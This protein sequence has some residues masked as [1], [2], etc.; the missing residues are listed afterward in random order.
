MVAFLLSQ[1]AFMRLSL[2][3]AALLFQGTLPLFCTPTVVVGSRHY[4]NHLMFT[5]GWK[6]LT[7]GPGLST[8]SRFIHTSLRSRSG[9]SP[10]EKLFTTF[11]KLFTVAMIY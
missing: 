7:L 10:F 11:G 9:Y 8:G 6:I 2:A 1:T 5:L 4:Y 3:S